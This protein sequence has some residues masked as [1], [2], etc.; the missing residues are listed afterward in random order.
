MKKLDVGTDAQRAERIAE[1]RELIREG[2]VE[3]SNCPCGC[4]IGQLKYEPDDPRLP[5]WL[6]GPPVLH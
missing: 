4:G 3:H 2:V 5:E 6:R 1:L